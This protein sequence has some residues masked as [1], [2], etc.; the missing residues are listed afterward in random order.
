MSFVQ[1]NL[2]AVCS[3]TN[4]APTYHTKAP[5]VNVSTVVQF[6]LNQFD[7]CRD[8]INQTDYRNR[9]RKDSFQD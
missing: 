3:V 6:N 5:W 8:N 9:H 7:N 4:L 2:N 1:F